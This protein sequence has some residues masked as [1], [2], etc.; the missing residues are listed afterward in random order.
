M[1]GKISHSQPVAMPTE[2]TSK[3][4]ASKQATPAQVELSHE[5][6]SLQSAK[7]S[8]ESAPDVDMDKVAEMKAMLK[9]G[10]VSVSLDSLAD[11]MIDFYQG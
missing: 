9:S 10:N 7:Q 3:T 11:S 5:M 8:M 1:I 4:A 6:K 2:A